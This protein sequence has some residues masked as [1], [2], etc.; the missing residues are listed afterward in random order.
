MRGALT[1]CRSSITLLLLAT[2]LTSS[3]GSRRRRGVVVAAG[4]RRLVADRYYDVAASVV[5]R[6]GLVAAVAASLYA[7]FIDP[8]TW[9]K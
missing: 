5:D 1:G 6:K 9:A 8:T 7:Y 4:R 3:I 2:A